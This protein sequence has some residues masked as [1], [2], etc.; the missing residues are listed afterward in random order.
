MMRKEI[1][2]HLSIT[3]LMLIALFMLTSFH[4]KNVT[5]DSVIT[6]LLTV[7]SDNDSVKTFDL[8]IKGKKDNEEAF[9]KREKSLKTPFEL[10]LEKGA[11]SI[12]IHGTSNEGKVIVKVEMLVD[13]KVKATAQAREEIILLTIDEENNIGATVM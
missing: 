9:Y 10:K 8:L 3:G 5:N 12:V 13:G 11:Y 7:K 4:T 2:N 1:K 6:N